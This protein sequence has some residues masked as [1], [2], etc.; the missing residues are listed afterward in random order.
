MCNQN[1]YDTVED[2]TRQEFASV[3]WTH[4]IHEKQAD[5]Y[6]TRYHLIEVINIICASLTAAG[7]ISS[8]FQDGHII[9][10]G[11]A[12]LAFAT[13]FCTAYI[14]SFNVQEKFAKHRQTAQKLIVVR[15]NYINLIA[16]I[17]LKNKTVDELLELYSII[18][19][20]LH[21]IY[22]TAPS[23]TD[24]AVEKATEA[25][26]EKQEYSYSDE[27][28]DRFLPLNLRKGI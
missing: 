4:K 13:I 3:V 1:S 5:I 14:K 20:E 19:E 27:E 16:N 17:K 28:I 23:T 24:K 21:R 10:V 8:I 25:L 2:I 15:N 26:S 7:V 11:T 6:E 18:S 9:K 12:L 22:E